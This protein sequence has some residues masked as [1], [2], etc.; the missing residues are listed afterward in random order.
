MQEPI[1][2]QKVKHQQ[3]QTVNQ[4]PYNFTMTETHSHSSEDHDQDSSGEDTSEENSV[5]LPPIAAAS[6]WT[7]RDI[8]A[9]KDSVRKEGGEGIIRVGHGETVTVKVPTHEDSTCLFWEFATDGYDIG[10]GLYFEWTNTPGTQVS[11]HISDSDEEEDEDEEMDDLSGREDIERGPSHQ[12][13][14]PISVVIPVYRRDCH[15]EVFMGS[16]VYPGLGIYQL[17][18]DNS[19]SLWRSKTLYYRVYYTQ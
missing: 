9:F 14:L 11:V 10:F 12:G 5:E 1:K 17:K 15:E 19:Y 3:N 6:L 18:F 8:K 13:H 2:E 16:H 7:Q 4:Y